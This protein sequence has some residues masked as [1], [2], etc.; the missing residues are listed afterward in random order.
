MKKYLKKHH[1]LML[2]IL[3]TANYQSFA[4]QNSEI[5]NLIQKKRSYNKLL[6]K[7][8]GYKIQL[9]NGNE[10]KAYRVRD[11]FKIKYSYYI[12]VGYKAPD[13]KV[14]VGNFKTRLEADRALNRIKKDFAGAFILK[15]SIQI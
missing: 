1:I 3:I 12:K 9:Y 2:I 10:G 4:Q 8:N 13:F 6:T 11:A 7:T 5:N 14:Q 15:T